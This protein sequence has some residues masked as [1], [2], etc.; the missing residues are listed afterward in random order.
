MFGA[1]ACSVVMIPL[2]VLTMTKFDGAMF[3]RLLSSFNTVWMCFWFSLWLVCTLAAIPTVYTWRFEQT[4]SVLEFGLGHVVTTLSVV[5]LFAIVVAHDSFATMSRPFRVGCVAVFLIAA[6]L[7]WIYE[8]F[9]LTGM[10]PAFAFCVDSRQMVCFNA[11][12]L[13]FD[14][15]FCMCCFLIRNMSIMLVYPDQVWFVG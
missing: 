11:T 7:D 8:R 1:L 5:F 4:H 3:P 15:W 13:R 12:R 2:L 14:A 6:L 9:V 10:P